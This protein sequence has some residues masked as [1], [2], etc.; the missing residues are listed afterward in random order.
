M[1][2]RFKVADLDEP[3]IE[4]LRRLEKSMGKV[5]VALEPSQE[6]AQ[7]STNQLADLQ[8]AEQELG[9]VLLAYEQA[10]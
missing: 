7:L 9:I 3:K 10:T 2:E 5:A 1:S 4:A 8:Q 6:F